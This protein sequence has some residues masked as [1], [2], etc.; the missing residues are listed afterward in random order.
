MVLNDDFAFGIAMLRSM[1]PS[2]MALVHKT[3]AH[4]GDGRTTE[5]IQRKFYWPTYKRDIMHYVLSC[6]C[7]M[8]KKS[9]SRRVAMLQA[10][11]L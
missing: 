2:I 9:A 11:F 1:I 8:R 4:P 10:R 5:L 3:Y 6:G 7:R